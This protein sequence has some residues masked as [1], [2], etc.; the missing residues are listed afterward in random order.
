MNWTY[1]Y[2]AILNSAVY[3]A[4]TRTVLWP[5]IDG[6][7]VA[8]SFLR[9]W[10]TMN[11]MMIS[12]KP[13]K[14]PQILESFHAYTDPPHCSAKSRHVIPLIRKMAPTMSICCIFSF[15][16]LALLARCGDLKKMRTAA[17]ATAP[18]G[19]LIQKHLMI[20]SN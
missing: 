13:K 5:R 7:I 11:M 2:M 18:N 9:I 3:N 19:R 20:E 10:M 6:G 12:P 16:D 8:I 14:R 4:L 17:K 1:V 15:N